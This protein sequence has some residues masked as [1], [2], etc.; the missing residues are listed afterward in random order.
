MCQFFSSDIFCKRA[1]IF[2]FYTLNFT[3][4]IV[5]DKS[6]FAVIGGDERQLA[7]ANM[8]AAEGS[9]VYCSGFEHSAQH[10][11]GAAS[12]DPLTAALMADIVILPMP[13]TRDGETLNAPLSCYRIELDDEYCAAIKDKIVFCGMADKLREISPAYAQLNIFDYSANPTF[14]I[15]NAQATAEGA[16]AEIIANFTRT[17]CGSRILITGYGRISGFLAPMLRSMGGDVSIAARKSSDR[18]KIVSYGMSALTFCRAARKANEFD[19]IINTVPERVI[20][21]GFIERISP[22][23]LIIELSSAPGGIDLAECE[24]KN[25]RV[26]QAKALPGKYSPVSAA[27]IIKE[28]VMSVLEE[29]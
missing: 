1:I 12:T 14:L 10:L 21:S 6:I 9:T 2:A 23:T 29:D 26:I 18:A 17:V 13:P 27:E 5:L 16:V 25:I 7:L 19:V 15:R 8:L 11:I 22:D 20:D 3:E 24:K 28:T 4:V